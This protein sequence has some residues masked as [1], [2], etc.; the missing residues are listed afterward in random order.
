MRQCYNALIIEWDDAKIKV[1]KQRDA[2][3]EMFLEK[4][5]GVKKFTVD[6]NR[7]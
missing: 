4:I 5:K 2:G 1:Q 7:L 3:K 6:L